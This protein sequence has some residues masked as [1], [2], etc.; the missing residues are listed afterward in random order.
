MPLLICSLSLEVSFNFLEFLCKYGHMAGN[1]FLHDFFFFPIQHNYFEMDPL[2]CVSVIVHSFVLLSSIHFKAI[3][4]CTFLP[5]D[6][7]WVVSRF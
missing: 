2:C 5:T 6:G 4:Q 1:S 3:A 7:H